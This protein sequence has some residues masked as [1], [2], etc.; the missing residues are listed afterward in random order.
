MINNEVLINN[1]GLLLIHV[2]M[3]GVSPKMESGKVEFIY[4]IRYEILTIF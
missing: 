3:G 4:L 1:N 2:I